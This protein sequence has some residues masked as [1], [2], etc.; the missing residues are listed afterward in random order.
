MIVRKTLAALL[1][2][3]FA[4][5]TV[6]EAADRRRVIVGDTS[7]IEIQITSETRH[8]GAVDPADVEVAPEREATSRPRRRTVE[9]PALPSA[10]QIQRR[11][12]APAER[13]LKRS[14][15]VTV[16]EFK[17]RPELRR[18]APSIDIQAINFGFAS[19]EI[20]YSQYGKVEVIADAIDGM[21]RRR[22]DAQILIEGHTDAVG[23]FA[24]NQRLSEARAGSLKR[25]LVREFGIPS[26]AL[27][28]VGYGEDFLLVETQYEDWRNRRVTLR[29]IDEFVRN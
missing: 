14:E 9:E 27:E 6:A 22:P 23:S 18:A 11:L 7:G 5:P 1:V 24:T 2:T 12:E 13:S 15:R 8:R 20:P 19:A 16:R 26:Y 21:L 17:R 29:R 25:L 3:A 10:A 4:L 28:T